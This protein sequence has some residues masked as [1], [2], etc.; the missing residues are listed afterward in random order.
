MHFS[1]KEYRDPLVQHIVNVSLAH[2][3]LDVRT[4]A[5]GALEAIVRIE[6]AS[7]VPALIKSQVRGCYYRNLI[8]LTEIF[9]SS[10]VWII[11]MWQNCTELYSLLPHSLPPRSFYQ[12]E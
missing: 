5:A 12:P 10:L 4:L 11:K 8:W 2:Y 1:Y 6:P 3:D 9:L 7:L